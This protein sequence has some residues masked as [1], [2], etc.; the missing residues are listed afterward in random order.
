MTKILLAERQTLIRQVLKMLLETDPGF[1]VVAEAKDGNEVFSKLRQFEVDLLL[2]DLTMADIAGLELIARA[3]AICPDMKILVLQKHAGSQLVTQALRNGVRGFITTNQDST[4]FLKALHK[5]ADGA[6]YID[7]DIAESMLIDNVTGD[8]K[9]MHTRLSPRE[10]EIFRLLVAGHGVN[11]IAD[12]LIISNKTV[13]SHK[14]MLMGKMHFSSMADLMRYALQ[15]NLFEENA[16]VFE[17]D[18][19]FLPHTQLSREA[20]PDRYIG[21]RIH[22]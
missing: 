14:K 9:S 2:V 1:E 19:Q 11:D 6:R 21:I 18:L 20:P 3:S 16:I 8:D 12:L 10:L 15:R 7:P 5:V 13:S 17:Q 4:E 22:A